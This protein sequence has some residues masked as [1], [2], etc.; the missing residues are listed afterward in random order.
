MGCV[1]VLV[2]VWVRYI[3]MPVLIDEVATTSSLAPKFHNI[4]NKLT[5]EINYPAISRAA[6]IAL[7]FA[8]R[9]MAVHGH[10]FVIFNNYMSNFVNKNVHKYTV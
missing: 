10:H 2:D 4:F 6:Y 1:W 7:T 3:T 8:L 5:I 9:N